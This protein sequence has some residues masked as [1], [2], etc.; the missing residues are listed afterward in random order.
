MKSI[1]S[2]TVD[3]NKSNEEK[4]LIIIY[5]SGNNIDVFSCTEDLASE[6]ITN[7]LVYLFGL[8]DRI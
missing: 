7:A 6:H 8:M 5:I 4:A 1:R 2:S 3:C